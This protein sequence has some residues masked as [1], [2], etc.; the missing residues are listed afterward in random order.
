MVNS[1]SDSDE[2]ARR[3]EEVRNQSRKNRTT[4]KTTPRKSPKELRRS[5]RQELFVPNPFSTPAASSSS[6][7]TPPSTVVR[8]PTFPFPQISLANLN[9]SIYSPGYYSSSCNKRIHHSSFNY[10]SRN[11][12]SFNFILNSYYAESLF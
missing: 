1:D 6:L 12:T 9:S 8:H 11:S 5:E 3:L 4:P 7:L 2:F 10:S